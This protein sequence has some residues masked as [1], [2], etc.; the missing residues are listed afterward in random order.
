MPPQ[1]EILAESPLVAYIAPIDADPKLQPVLT[2]PLQKAFRATRSLSG[3]SRS[4]RFKLTKLLIQPLEEGSMPPRPNLSIVVK[5]T[6]PAQVSK[7]K[8]ANSSD[9]GNDATDS[10][11]SLSPVRGRL[12]AETRAQIEDLAARGLTTEEIALRTSRSVAAVRKVLSPDESMTE[13]LAILDLDR[14]IDFLA[15]L[16]E[17]AVEEVNQLARLQRE[18]TLLRSSLE[19]RIRDIKKTK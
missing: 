3:E 14:V 4:I 5:E 19:I 7:K 11:E 1:R 9:T 12:P 16:P 2:G 15:G 13:G 6:G 17:E 8:G 10:P 18:R